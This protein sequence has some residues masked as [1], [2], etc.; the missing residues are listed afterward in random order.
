[1]A[2]GMEGRA[3]SP[4]AQLD[5]SHV[6]LVRHAHAGDR[7]R[8]TGPDEQRPLSEKGWSQARGLVTLL[9]GEHIDAIASSPSLRCVQTVKPL[10]EARRAPVD[11]LDLLVEGRDPHEA[12]TWLREQAATRSIAA[13]SHGDIIP[14]VL[15]LAEAAGA[16]LP[17][18]RRWQKG[19][20]W[21]L[22]IDRDRWI[23]GHYLPPPA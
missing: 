8:W 2:A 18:D 15:D 5:M 10:A 9:D 12:F 6:Y 19:S 3:S 14:G 16:A 17:A 4:S 22:E 21:V 20:T 23:G 7:T 1:M 11:E 13:C